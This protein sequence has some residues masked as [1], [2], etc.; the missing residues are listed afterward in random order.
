M[1]LTHTVEQYLIRLL[2]PEDMK[3]ATKGRTTYTGQP[4]TIS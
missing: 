1:V 4:L 2:V 3:K